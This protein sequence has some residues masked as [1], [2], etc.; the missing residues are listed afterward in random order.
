MASASARSRN[1]ASIGLESIRNSSAIVSPSRSSAQ[2]FTAS[3]GH[4]AVR[5]ESGACK[6]NW[7]KPAAIAAIR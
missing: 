2:F 5:N 1:A 7:G 3:R 4:Q 6:F